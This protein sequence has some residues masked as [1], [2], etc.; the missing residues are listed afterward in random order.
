MHGEPVTDPPGE[1]VL[2]ELVASVLEAEL[3]ERKEVL[4]R[5]AREHPS[6]AERVARRLA[7]LGEIGFSADE[8][9]QPPSLPERFGS[10]QRLERVGAGGM[11]EVYLAR[12]AVSGELAAIKLVRTD[13]LWFEAARRRFRR[14]VEAV[15]GLA[16]P[17]IVRVL[18]VGEEQGMPW[19]A[20]EWV[21][22]ASLE[23]LVDELRG[24]PPE[25]L[26]PADLERALRNASARRPHAEPAREGAFPGRSY[27]E[28]VTL[29]VARVARA[30]AHAH[31]E[32]VLHRDVKPS[33]VLATPS[34]RV[35][36]ADFGLAR[37]S[38]VERVT[39]TGVWLGSLPYAA[40]EQ[41]EGSPEEL[42]ARA[43][44]YALGVTLYDLL[45]LRTP[46]LGGPESAVRKRIAT[47]DLEPPRKLNPRIPP[48]LERVC[49]AA[50]DPD[51][52]RRPA[53][54]AQFADDLQRALSG[55]PV[56]ARALP[57]RVRAQRWSRRRPRQALALGAASLLV[58]A[59]TA[60]GVRERVVAAELTRLS[61]I[62]LARGLLDEAQ[63]FWPARRE[64]L[65]R[66]SGW[67]E[68]AAIVRERLPEYERALAALEARAE[69]YSREDRLQDQSAARE[70]LAGLAREID[71]LA[72][73]VER[74]GYSAPAPPP[75]PEAARR[76]DDELARRLEEDP[77]AVVRGLADSIGA[78]RQ[79][80]HAEPERWRPDER[81]LD[82]FE[83]IL[84]QASD[85]LHQRTSFRF[86]S[87][88]ESWRQHALVRLLADVRRL[89]E[90]VP[91]VDEQRAATQ[92][93]ARR[94]EGAG[95]LPW[96]R[97][98]A[99][100]AASPRYAGLRLAPIFGLAPLGENPA[101]HLW[102]FLDLRSG[103]EPVREGERWRF[104]ESS[105][106]VLVLV[107]GGRYELGER[108]G[109]GPPERSALPLHA[110]ELDPFLIGSCELSV[111]QARR[112]GGL[113][114]E[115]SLPADG[116]LP[117]AIDWARG[118]ALLARHGYEL[119]TEAQWECAARGGAEDALELAGFA[120][121]FDRSALAQAPE[122]RQL[123]LI[124]P[125]D[126]DDGFVRAAPIASFFPN[127]FGL[128]DTL[129][130]LS[131]WCLDSHVQRGFS[132]LVPRVRDGLR[133]TVVS[134]QLRA[135]RGGSYQDGTNVCRVYMRFGEAPG[136]SGPSIGLRA[137]RL[138]RGG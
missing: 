27:V 121:V 136:K 8:P 19:L 64:N 52:A 5:L 75:D 55:V 109:E 14:E 50:L 83:R 92:D 58:L 15:S 95:A 33:N 28:C 132:T 74:G 32:G 2:E 65:G 106:I 10:W 117:L 130:N 101:T 51:R 114:A 56:R 133:A 38:G 110:V 26:T 104:D 20:L 99:A 78:L 134:A 135:W 71:G 24:A 37:P 43:D 54:A 93:L 118:R 3:D 47:G 44:V 62:E 12:H 111:G 123:A 72:G 102:E 129:G 89:G 53:D 39:R 25:A 137:V 107:P 69:P 76:S 105:G 103:A 41:V 45:T 31:E 131:E 23:E 119:P 80:M 13:H 6:Q 112:L 87:S 22:G 113:P 81:Q 116:R 57:W 49:L 16:H 35:L 7:V 96:E 125:A 88:V 1:D 124:V 61:D 128:F 79:R 127:G 90:L 11:G 120:N 68:R 59:A 36:L 29:L 40:P 82:D 126:F 84:Q 108:E 85:Q 67:L 100:I 48:A 122:P 138:V 46:F 91:R 18:E 17:G 66:M 60:F 73:F 97:A 94:A 34:G 115:L 42:D 21:G 77:D 4:E 30:L 9:R 70:T 63:G 86:A 98:C